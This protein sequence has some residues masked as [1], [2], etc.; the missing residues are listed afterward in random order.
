MKST[1][2]NSRTPRKKVQPKSG[3]QKKLEATPA[4]EQYLLNALLDNIPDSIYFKDAESCFIRISKA[5]ANAFGL[6][7]PAQA[8]GKSDFDFFTE[9]HA[10]QAYEDEQQIIRTGRSFGKEETETWADRPDTWVLTTKMPLR[11]H[12]GKIVGTFGISKNITERKQMEVEL[13]REKQFLEALIFNCPVSIVVLDTDDKIIS[14]NPAFEKLYG[15]LESEIVNVRLDAIVK[16]P[17]TSAQPREYMM[18]QARSGVVQAI[19]KR[20]R[21]DGSLVDVQIFGV[22]VVVHQEKIGTLFI[23]HDITELVLAQ[24][25]AERANRAK[26]EF[27]ANMSHEIRTPMNGVIGMLELALDTSLTITWKHLFKVQ[28]HYS[29][30]SMIFLTSPRSR[31]AN[32]SWIRST[33]VFATL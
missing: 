11:D 30:Y 29:H 9:A 21:R 17:E 32:W 15:Y 33:S 5:L 12:E 20:I 3:K 16:S 26:S 2:R 8:I 1:K 25:E 18:H 14:C 31:R 23:Y 19:G 4:E 28:K 7:D 22:P 13:L 10:R 6:S 24:Q 27:L